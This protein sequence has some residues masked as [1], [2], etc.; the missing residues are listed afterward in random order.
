MAHNSNDD[1][2]N[3]SGGSL[4]EI[5]LTSLRL[6]LTSF[7]GPV[8]HLAYFKEEYVNKKKWLDDKLYADII[9]VCQF[10]PGPASSQVGISIGMLRGGIAGG[11]LSFLGFTLPSVLVLII[12]ALLY[13]TLNLEGAVF[14]NSLKVV[15]V[16]VVLHALLG[17]GKNLAP[18][19]PRMLMAIAAA[20]LML[21]YPNAWIQ[22]LTILLGGLI[23][24]FLFKNKSENKMTGFK[25]N[26]TRK[27][28]IISFSTLIGLLVLLPILN[29]LFDNQYLNI[30]DIFF[31]VGSIVFGGGHV[32]LPM[33]E[34]EVVPTGLI[35]ADEFLAGYGMAQAVPGPLFTFASYLGAVMLGVTGGFIAMI[36]MFLPSFLLVMSALPFLNILRGNKKFQSVLMGVN[37]TVVGILLAAFYDP[38]FISGINSGSDFFLALLLFFLLYKMKVPAWM[39]VILGVA[40][41][42]PLQL[43]PGL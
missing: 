43:L 29:S 35:S 6:G 36:A 7:G 16:A 12:F 2:N 17:M 24:Y 23:G 15:A 21:I 39:I 25:F 28:A 40:A 19:I 41:G 37:A 20:G 26:L 3:Q 8:A 9:A 38:V 34:R 4:I 33:I 30:F 18:D 10:L 22:I 31:R 14:I 11:V 13:Q 5:L 27:M 1:N 42:Y 32:V